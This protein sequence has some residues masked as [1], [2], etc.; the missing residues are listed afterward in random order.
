MINETKVRVT[1]K[2][3][4]QMGVVYYGNYF[5]WQEIGRT[6]LLRSLGYTYKQMEEEKVLLPVIEA[7]CRYKHP[8]RYDDMVLIKTRIAE[9]SP[10][11]IV[12]YYEMMNE[13]GDILLAFGSTSH[14]F[15]NEAGRPINLKKRNPEVWEIVSQAV[16]KSE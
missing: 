15:V 13:S 11:R 4:D 2:D 8:A 9:L 5:T 12:F 7:T 14:A 16:G 6:E 10:V 3:T 1:Y